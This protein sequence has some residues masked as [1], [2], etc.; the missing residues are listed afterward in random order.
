MAAETAKTVQADCAVPISESVTDSSLNYQKNDA[1]PPPAASPTVI[2]ISESE[3][4]IFKKPKPIPVEYTDLVR[5]IK[6]TH[7]SPPPVERMKMIKLQ[8][9]NATQKVE[10]WDEGPLR[11]ILAWTDRCSGDNKWGTCHMFTDYAQLLKKKIGDNGIVFTEGQIR[12]FPKCKKSTPRRMITLWRMARVEH[13]VTLD[14]DLT[15]NTVTAYDGLSLLERKDIEEV[16]TWLTTI[17]RTASPPIHARQWQLEKS[18]AFKQ[19]DGHSCAF[20]AIECARLLAR[21]LPVE[22]DTTPEGIRKMKTLLLEELLCME[23]LPRGPA[24]DPCLLGLPNWSGMQCWLNSFWVVVH[25]L[26]PLKKLFSKLVLCLPLIERYKGKAAKKV[27]AMVRMF[28]ELSHPVDQRDASRILASYN[29][30]LNRFK[31]WDDQGSEQ[32][33]DCMELFTL[34]V[35]G[36]I[37]QLMPESE[38]SKVPL[39]MQF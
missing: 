37:P 16:K 27:E 33:Q 10:N 19:N 32:H 2:D 29:E 31:L 25:Y 39:Y 7:S 35:F 18:T 28:G 5:W 15:G 21:D 6:L 36:A 22:M 24:R 1:Q 14:V 8:V 30:I 3:T 38:V 13:F 4:D 17:L 26:P 12:C 23:I 9:R 20:L 34:G 11:D